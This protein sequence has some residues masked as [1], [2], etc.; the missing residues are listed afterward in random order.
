MRWLSRLAILPILFAVACKEEAPTGSHYGNW[1]GPNPNTQPATQ[2]T[3]LPLSIPTVAND[4]LFSINAPWTLAAPGATYMWSHDDLDV[5][6]LYGSLALPAQE[7]IVAVIDTGIDRDHEDLQGR[8][9]VNVGESSDANYANSVDDD[10]NGYADDFI[11]WNFVSD[12]NNP[13]D[14]NGHGT[15]VSGTIAAIGGNGVGIMG[16]AP[17]VRVMPLKVCGASGGCASSDIRAAIDYA[18]THGAKVINISLGGVD[19]G[20]DSV[21]FDNAITDATQNGAL[22]VVAAGN[23]AIDTSYMTPAN[24][25]HAVAVAAHRTDGG[26][27]TFSDYGFK[28]DL[29]APGCALRDGYEVSGILSLNS[30]KCGNGSSFCSNRVVGTNS[31]SLKQGT[32]M[33]SPHVAGMAAV[34]WTASPDATPLQIRQAMLRTA[35]AIQAGK[36]NFDFGAGKLSAT[37]LIA[38]AQT[39]PGI[40]ITSPRY[41]T[42]ASSHTLGIRVEARAHNV[43]WA[44]RYQQ[45]PFPDN[46]DYLAGTAI[47]A[48]GTVSNGTAVDLTETFTPP[49]SGDYLVIL[50]ATANGQTYYDLTLVSKP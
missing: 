42:S 5:F 24:A 38:E 29:S 30:S 26:I 22:V 36:K 3:Q 23:S 47:G 33:A 40:K 4:A 18:V 12:M 35:R 13:A 8:L 48:G 15:H 14:D 25:T 44:L 37:N 34:A 2:Y 20:P 39:A 11:G 19:Q 16:V 7:L 43:T 50:E 46:V 41:G 17:W 9:W 45:S 49:A 21:A 6:S 31:Y 27:C 1:P 10:G 32:S 28:L